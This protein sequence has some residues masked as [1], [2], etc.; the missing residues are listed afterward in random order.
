MGKP[1]ILHVHRLGL[2]EWS[3]GGVAE[4]STTA[5]RRFVEVELLSGGGV[6]RSGASVLPPPLRSQL[7]A[8]AVRFRPVPVAE[9]Q[10]R[11]CLKVS[12]LAGVDIQ[13]EGDGGVARWRPLGS[14][15]VDFP[16]AMGLRPIQGCRGG[17][18]AARR[19]H[20][21]FVSVAFL[22]LED[23][24]VIFLSFEVGLVRMLD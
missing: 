10:R 2:E 23:L 7:G 9:E 12:K 14:R 13:I 1:R 21:F 4:R 19:R 18:A 17:A 6:L 5:V 16:T 20:V 11:R 3:A 24:C 22:I 15:S 8:A